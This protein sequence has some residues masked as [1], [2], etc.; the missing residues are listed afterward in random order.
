VPV[1]T[2]LGLAAGLVPAVDGD[3]PPHPA[4]SSAVAATALVNRTF[5]GMRRLLI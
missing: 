4:A 5:N 1:A 2:G 3:D